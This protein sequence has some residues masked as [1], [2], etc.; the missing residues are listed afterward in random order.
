MSFH[1]EPFV[2]S[3][4]HLPIPGLQL[5]KTAPIRQLPA[6][7]GATFTNFC[8]FWAIMFNRNMMFQR[9]EPASLAHAELI[10]RKL[11]KWA[12]ELPRE[13]KRGSHASY[14][15]LS[16]HIWLHTAIVHLLRPYTGVEPQPKLASFASS[17]A[18]PDNVVAASI[19][20][21]KRIVYTYRLRF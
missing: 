14:H 18:T 4:P 20:Q 5:P 12:S 11:L 13:I 17:D 21:L 19:R 9:K 10:Y 8:K 7:M 1:K 2:K 6:Y 16:L 3:V 15:A